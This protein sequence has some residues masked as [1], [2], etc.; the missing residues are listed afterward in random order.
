MQIVV[1][2]EAL[3]NNIVDRTQELEDKL[4]LLVVN[5]EDTCAFWEKRKGALAGIK[6]CFFC[7][8]YRP[9]KKD[10]KTGA[11]VFKRTIHQD[12]Q[13]EERITE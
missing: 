10:E 13:T 8:Y 12:L 7:Q 6:R 3:T 11:C 1:E 5:S 4:K 9:Q 2:V